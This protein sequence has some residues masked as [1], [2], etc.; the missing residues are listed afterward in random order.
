MEFVINALSTTAPLMFFILLVI[1]IFGLVRISQK[2]CN[3][4]LLKVCTDIRDLFKYRGS[5]DISMRKEDPP[6]IM[7]YASFTLSSLFSLFIAFSILGSIMLYAISETF[8]VF[9]LTLLPSFFSITFDWTI[10]VI[11]AIL[12]IF[13]GIFACKLSSYYIH[14]SSLPHAHLL[15]QILSAVILILSLFLS[16]NSIGSASDFFKFSLLIV[17]TSALIALVSPVLKWN[18]IKSK[19]KSKT[20]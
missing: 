2:Q 3:R 5:F 10:L 16:F 15:A 14:K 7:T 11:S 4:I 9:D 19:R 1:S 17:S 12:L 8:A 6:R 18:Q 13:A 20:A